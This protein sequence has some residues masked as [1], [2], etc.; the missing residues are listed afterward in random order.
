MAKKA[1]SKGKQPADTPSP[2]PEDSAQH[3]GQVVKRDP[4]AKV[5][6]AN[7][8]ELKNAADDLVKE[9]ILLPPDPPLLAFF[10]ARRPGVYG[11]RVEFQESKY[12]VTVGVVLYVVLNTALALYVACV[13][14]NIIFEGKRKTFASRISTERLTISSLAAS[15]ATSYTSSTWVPF[16][17][18]LVTPSPTI[19]SPPP[20]SPSISTSSS[21]TSPY[22]LYSLTL[23]Y[24]HSANANKSLLHSSSRVLTRPFAELFDSEGRIA[25]AEVER[26]LEQGLA[27]LQ[28]GG[29]RGDEAEGRKSSYNGEGAT[30]TNQDR[31]PGVSG[32][33][34]QFDS[35]KHRVIPYFSHNIAERRG[36]DEDPADVKVLYHAAIR[37]SAL[38]RAQTDTDAGRLY[39]TAAEHAQRAVE[40]LEVLPTKYSRS[41]RLLLARVLLVLGNI[42]AGEPVEVSPSDLVA[43]VTTPVGHDLYDVGCVWRTLTL[44]LREDKGVCTPVPLAGDRDLELTYG[45]SRRM[46]HILSRVNDLCSHARMLW[47]ALGDTAAGLLAIEAHQLLQEA[48]EVT[49]LA[50][51][52]ETPRIRKGTEMMF[53]CIRLLLSCEVLGEVFDSSENAYSRMRMARLFAETPQMERVLG[54]GLP[55]TVAAVYCPSASERANLVAL[56]RDISLGRSPAGVELKAVQVPDL[57]WALAAGAG[58][59]TQNRV[60][61]WREACRLLSVSILL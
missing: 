6:N 4:A 1:A 40:A 42:V 25:R 5:N 59:L 50:E 52:D 9:A 38:H 11:Y 12:W 20:S 14:K 21:S 56:L 53:H 28:G 3:D 33:P 36:D 19:P 30:P 26:W 31:V 13:E 35:F 18:S 47:S 43:N 58:S 61:P 16:P 44:C 15:S 48:E 27:E 37:F 23:S 29:A 51:A 22:P 17:L 45:L 24:A 8:S 39:D 41:E 7:L 60:L 54:Y 55:L 49:R 2:L 34:H 10:P 32:A 57:A 46:W